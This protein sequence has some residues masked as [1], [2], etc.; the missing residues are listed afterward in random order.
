MDWT[1]VAVGAL[2]AAAAIGGGLGSQ[3]LAARTAVAREKAEWRRRAWESR[4]DAYLELLAQITHLDSAS[5]GAL[6]SGRPR[7]PT[8][9]ST[10]PFLRALVAAEFHAEPKTWARMVPLTRAVQLRANATTGVPVPGIREELEAVGATDEA[11]WRRLRDEFLLAVREDLGD[12][13]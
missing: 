7:N 2:T 10:A 5:S 11:G 3:V 13:P 4:R 1:T 6:A 8:E 12:A 9:G